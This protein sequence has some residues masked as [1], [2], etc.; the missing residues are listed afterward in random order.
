[1]RFSNA[2]VQSWPVS[3]WPT[4]GPRECDAAEGPARP[5]TAWPL[6]LSTSTVQFSSLSVEEACE[7]IASLGFAA[8]DFWHSGFGCPHLDEIEKRLGPEG[9]KDLLAKHRLKLYAFTCY[10]VGTNNG[11]QRFAEILGKAGG[12]VA[13]REAR[14][15]KTVNLTAEMKSLLEQL[16]PQLE[17]AEKYHSRI[18][19]ENHGNSLLNSKD[20]FKAFV[21]LNRNPRWGSPWRRTIC[22]PRESR[23]RRSWGSSA[24]SCCSSMPGSMATACSNCRGSARPTSLLGSRPWPART[25][26]GTS[27]PLCTATPARRRWPR[28][29]RRPGTILSAATASSRRGHDYGRRTSIAPRCAAM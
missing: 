21:E 14:Y 15:G 27:I 3:D 17:L 7:R 9:L 10:G 24:S 20:S 22:R 26:P 28:D 6:R 8:V 29:W 25:M 2:Q 13:V 4:R 5:K 18:A 23:S 19:V 12:G 1:M 11:Y 16:K